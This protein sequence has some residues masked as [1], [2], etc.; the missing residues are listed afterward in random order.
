M[1]PLTTGALFCALFSRLSVFLMHCGYLYRTF[2][3]FR[4]ERL[5]CILYYLQCDLP[6]APRMHPSRIIY[7]TS[8]LLYRS[9]V[10]ILQRA[11]IRHPSCIPLTHLVGSVLHTCCAT[12]ASVAH[13]AITTVLVSSNTCLYVHCVHYMR[14]LSIRGARLFSK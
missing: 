8:A 6:T 3:P 13:L 7:C 5:P 12:N 14:I 4:P 1:E 9:S 10:I 2:I 11:C